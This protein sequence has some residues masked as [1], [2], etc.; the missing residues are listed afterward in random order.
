MSRTFS[1]RSCNLNLENIR[2][3]IAWKNSSDDS[4]SAIFEC[5]ATRG[6][7]GRVAVPERRAESLCKTTAIA[8]REP[9]V[10]KNT[11]EADRNA[12][13]LWSSKCTSEVGFTS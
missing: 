11:R 5:D 13:A 4:D 7:L 1:C 2:Y 8:F 12:A 10:T 6:F 3:N 9:Y